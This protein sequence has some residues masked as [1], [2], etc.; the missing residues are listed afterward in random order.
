MIVRCVLKG[1]TNN[2]DFDDLKQLFRENKNRAS[3]IGIND[4][5]A[6]AAA[7]GFEAIFCEGVYYHTDE[8]CWIVLNRG[9]LIFQRTGLQIA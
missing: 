8:R 9:A 1:N 4:A 5:G 3:D 2:I 6:F 7:L